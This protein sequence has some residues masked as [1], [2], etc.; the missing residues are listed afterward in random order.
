V[1]AVQGL[2][3][4]DRD[5]EGNN[6]AYSAELLTGATHLVVATEALNAPSRS[7]AP[8][9]T[10]DDLGQITRVARI[11]RWHRAE[12]SLEMGTQLV[13]RRETAGIV[14]RRRG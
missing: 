6:P 9:L 4:A 10:I 11:T 8:T 1:G 12:K 2:L 7:S 5:A 13:C 14:A 3:A